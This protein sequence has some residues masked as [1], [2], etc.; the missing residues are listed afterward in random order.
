MSYQ[1]T[2][3]AGAEFFGV[4]V[5]AL[6]G[7]F[8][9]GCPVAQRDAQ[10]RITK[11]DLSDMARWRITRATEDG[12]GSELDH[13]RTRLTR[14]QADKTELEVAELRAE[15]VRAPV[16]GL[17]WQA[18][19][20]AM[21]AKL[22]SLPSKVAPQVAG[23]DSLS[24][25]QELIQ[26]VVHEA[27][28][29]IAGDGFPADVRKRLDMLRAGQSRDADREAATGSHGDAVGKRASAAK[30]RGQRGAGPVSKRSSAVPK[31][32]TRRAQ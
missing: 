12:G 6:D 20:A 19:V 15:L 5:Q 10:S 18:M 22:L 32:G 11:V 1:V 26:A 21:R 16:I 30:P 14:A 2:K 13:E 24:R 3:R 23:P 28:A 31:R 4:S 29:E 17:H 7:W 27:L 9:A 25:T 8:S